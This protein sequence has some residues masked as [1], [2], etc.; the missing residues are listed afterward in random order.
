MKKV[1]AWMVAGA[2]L[3][4]M[5]T[6]CS[7]SDG[8][9][10][11]ENGDTGS[12][13]DSGSAEGG[14]ASGTCLIGLSVRGLDNPYY[15]ELEASAEAFSAEH[16]GMQVVTMEHHGDEQKQVNDIKSFLARG[17]SDCILYVDPQSA[18]INAEIAQLCEDAGVYWTS[19]WTMAEDV[20]PQDYQYYAAHQAVDNTAGAYETAK[21]MFESFPNQTGKVL[22]MEGALANDASDERTAGWHQALEEYP[23]VEVL[24][25]QVCDWDPQIGMDLAQTW[26][27]RYGDEIDGICC[28]NDSIA[29]AVIEGMKAKGKSPQDIKIIGF[30]GNQDAITSIKNGDM[31]A[32]TYANAWCQGAYGICTA[33]HAYTGELDTLTCDQSMRAYYSSGITVSSD[34]IDEFIRDYVD[35]KPELDYSQSFG[36]FVRAMEIPA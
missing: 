29:L 22:L 34:N 9:G 12:S 13:A 17:G 31:L 25:Q 14:S 20:Y 19:T 32:T 8:G 21:V 7:G 28:P 16:P 24:D 5:L 15:V 35:S 6:G 30:D 10:A 4:A 2:M 26:I 33:Y 1:L 3:A 11:A 36:G 23:N 18:T 27:T